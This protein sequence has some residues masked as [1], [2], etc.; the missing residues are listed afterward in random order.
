MAKTVVNEA[1]GAFG[2][3]T[4]ST[5]VTTPSMLDMNGVVDLLTETNNT[6]TNMGID[7]EQPNAM[8]DILRDENSANMYIDG[9]SEGLEGE[10]LKNFKT[11]CHTMLD[12]VN[13]RGSFAN[14]ALLSALSEDNVSAG[15]MPVS[16]LIFPM[17]RFTWRATCSHTI[18]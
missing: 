9:L 5:G 11:L 18:M 4:P 13:G 3:F 16:K 1:V 7:L 10:D 6:L 12:E 15:F 14:R 8:I 2:K 17:F